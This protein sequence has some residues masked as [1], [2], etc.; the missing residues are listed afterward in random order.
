MSRPKIAL[1]E[2]S[3]ERLSEA[4]KRRAHPPREMSSGSSKGPIH[5]WLCVEP[6]CGN[7]EYTYSVHEAPV[8]GGGLL[9]SFL[10]NDDFSS[11]VHQPWARKEF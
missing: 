1:H 2:V 10:T 5:M 6:W 9:F 7:T 4:E 11:R 3:Y 8:C